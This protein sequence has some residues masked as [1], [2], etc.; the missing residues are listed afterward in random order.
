[1]SD[2]FDKLVPGLNPSASVNTEWFVV[3][4][5]NEYLANIK[6]AHTGSAGTGS[7]KYSLAVVS[8]SGASPTKA[9]WQPFNAVLEEGEMY[10]VTYEIGPG[11]AV[12]VNV[13]SVNVSF[14]VS[15]LDI[16]KT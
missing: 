1:M 11:K 5:D 16:N 15:G 9:D 6:V 12:V 8:S 7:T 3:P 2:V 4:S 13:D 10:D 14:N